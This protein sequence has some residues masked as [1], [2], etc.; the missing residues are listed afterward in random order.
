MG[1]ETDEE[2][3][4]ILGEDKA[5]APKAAASNPPKRKFGAR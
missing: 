1:I 2:W 3:K 4:M 5:S